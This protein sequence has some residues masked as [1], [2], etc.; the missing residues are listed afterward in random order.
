MN[1]VPYHL[2][3][4]PFFMILAAIGGL[5]GA[6]FNQINKELSIFRRKY[7]NHIKWARILEA[8]IVGLITATIFYFIPL[9][10]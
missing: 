6:L 2:S 3:D 8:I 5:M 9:N 7:Y 1:S 10:K 4:I